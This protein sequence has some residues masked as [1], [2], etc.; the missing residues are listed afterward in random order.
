MDASTIHSTSG[1]FPSLRIGGVGIQTYFII[2][3]LVLCLCALWI[4]RRAQ[5]RL[6]PARRALD[7]FILAMLGGFLGSR[8]LHVLWE[9]PAYYFE[10]PWRVFDVISG[11]FVWYG[12]AIGAV[13]AIYLMLRFGY[14]D[15][16]ESVKTEALEWFD[17]FAPIAAMGYAGG[18]IA[19]VLT[20]CCFGRV[21]EWP[22][23]HAHVWFRFPTQGFA[24]VWELGAAFLLLRLERFSKS[25]PVLRRTRRTGDVFFAWLTLHGL[26]RVIMEALRADPRGPAVG[27]VTISMTVS[28][29]L[30]AIGV[31]GIRKTRV[32]K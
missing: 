14:R 27:P 17:F 24:V 19:C 21:C 29:I 11:G 26:G 23:G 1:F 18:R 9:E 10:S 7:L 32:S 16:R 22:F 3:S 12:G 20:G 13:L 5:S 15:T 31:L 2:I 8:L 6:M 25:L 4:P 28:L 30:I